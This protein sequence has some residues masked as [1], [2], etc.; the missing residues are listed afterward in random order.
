MSTKESLNNLDRDDWRD[1]G[2]IL[3]SLGEESPNEE[4]DEVYDFRGAGEMINYIENNLLL[5]EDERYAE[6]SD[7]SPFECPDCVDE[8]LE[9]S[10]VDVAYY[11][12]EVDSF[13]HSNDIQIVGY[14]EAFCREHD[15][16]FMRYQ[17]SWY[18]PE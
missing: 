17:E 3:S 9:D 16:E 6:H 15:N 5:S 12:E 11:A 8:D 10:E 1:F 7:I 18:I 13:K 2:I 4:L 14:W